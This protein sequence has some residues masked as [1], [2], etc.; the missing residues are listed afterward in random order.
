MSITIKRRRLCAALLAALMP[1][2]ALPAFAQDFPSKPVRIIAP[3]AAGGSA[4]TIARLLANE[5]GKRWGV[6]VIVE[7]KPGAGGN[8]GAEF[9]A[10]SP[11]DGSTFLISGAALTVNASL[12]ANA[13]Y[14]L[15]RTLLPVSHLADLPIVIA[16]NSELP[17][18]TVGDLVAHAKQ[19]PRVLNFG[20]AGMGTMGHV[21]GELFKYKSGVDVVHVPYRGAPA[22]AMDLG[23][24]RVHFMIDALPIVLPTI[25]QGKARL[26]ATTA[27][28]RLP[29]L[30][31][32]PTAIESGLDME[33]SSWLSLWAPGGTPAS[34]IER[35]SR[36]AAAALKVPEVRAALDAQGFQSV[37][38]SPQELEA[39]ARREMEK[40]AA[41]VRMTGVK[42]E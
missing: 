6:T 30:P 16:V 12:Q 25:Q 22:A 7:N 23:V 27:R 33:N 37:G 8:I 17:V 40:W 11:G 36:D 15:M 42:I 35:V 4:D 41:L 39:L 3:F 9:V 20:S 32:L 24:G 5:L 21:S 38:G 18:K 29:R 31:D 26:I 13:P 10:R 28:K 19:H 1:C 2:V 14:E 34:I